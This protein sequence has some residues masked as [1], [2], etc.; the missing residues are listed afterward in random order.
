M[1]F[2]SYRLALVRI[3][4]CKDGIAATEAALLFPIL[5]IMLMGVYDLGQGVVINQKVNTASQVI[6]DLVTRNEEVS[7]ALIED[8]I[9]AGELALMPFSTASFGYDIVSVEFDENGDPLELWRETENMT[10]DATA[11]SNSVGLGE[12]GEGVII[13]SVEYDYDPFFN[14]IFIDSF[15]MQERAYL[16]G[17]KSV[18]VPCIDC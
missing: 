11:V 3:G 1:S 2:K 14:N 8:I 12:E 4:R 9:N 17:R 10:P 13:V 6:G 5:F 7:L 18:T 16:R 15:M